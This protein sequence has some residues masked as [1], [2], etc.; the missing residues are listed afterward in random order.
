MDFMCLA[1]LR[2]AA[3]TNRLLSIVRDARFA[4][5]HAQRVNDCSFGSNL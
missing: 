5:H 4:E 2:E 3:I 1:T